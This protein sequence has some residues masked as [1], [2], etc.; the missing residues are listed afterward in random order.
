MR[1][2]RHQAFQDV[3]LSKEEIQERKIEVRSGDASIAHLAFL[4]AEYEPRCYLFVVFECVRRLML[5]GLLIFIYAGSLTQI[6]IGLLLAFLSY[7][8]MMDF[9]P[10]I[11][12]LDDRL[13]DVGQSQIVLVFIASLVLFAK[14]MPEQ[15][16]APGNLFRGPL[17]AF[18]MVMIGTMTLLMTFYMLV[19]EY[20]GIGSPTDAQAAAGSWFSRGRKRFSETK[21]PQATDDADAAPE[22]IV[23]TPH[24]A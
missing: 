21:V 11:E 24:G 18:V 1:D 6:T 5:T 10:Y 22:E 8:V 19:A 3:A 2:L 23:V 17:F 16:G 13:A 9:N 20:C 4:F 14:D 12:D 15:E 7:G